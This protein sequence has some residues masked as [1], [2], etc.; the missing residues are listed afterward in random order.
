MI[1]SAIFLLILFITVFSLGSCKRI[2][3]PTPTDFLDAKTF[4]AKKANLDAALSGVYAVLGNSA[5]YGEIYQ[6]NITAGTEEGLV[7]LSSYSTPRAGYF[8]GTSASSEMASLWTILYTGINRA[9]TVLENID[10]PTDITEEERAAIKGEA[11]FLRAY[12]YFLLTQWYGNVPLR[13]HSS[14]SADETNIAFT[15]SKDIY[16]FVIEEMT[17]ADS[18]LAGQTADMFTSNERVTQT[19]V[20][21]ILA[22]VCLYAAGNPVNDASRYQDAASW[23]RKVINSGL[24]Q[25]N[26]DYRQLF[27]LQ[28][29]DQYDNVNRESIWEVGFY[30]NTSSS[31]QNSGKYVRVG[32][33]SSNDLVGRCDGYVLVPP[34]GLKA[35]YAKNLVAV[36]G[37]TGS[38]TNDTTPDSR[39]DW[40][41][42]KFKYSG[43]STTV[44]PNKTALS[45]TNYW[46]RYPGKWRREE[47]LAPHDPTRS[48]A[49][50]PII[51]Y[52]DVLL[53]LAEA[54]NELNGPT[55]EA[56]DLVNQIRKRAY[57]EETSGKMLDSIRIING[58][59]G[60]TSAPTVTI[61]GG[62]AT[63]GATAR[64]IVSGGTV[65]GIYLSGLGSGYTSLPTI[66]ISGTGSGAVAEAVS[67]TDYR[68][69][70]E[71][72][73]SQEAFRKTI[74]DERLRELLGEF[75]RRQDLKRWGILEATVQQMGND[76]ENGNASL[77]IIAFP[78]TQTS[79]AKVHF[80]LPASNVSSK[81]VFLPIPQ[82]E[83]LYNNL[84]EQNPGY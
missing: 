63:T 38:V 1:R 54:E 71:Q 45:P 16:N 20:E 66:T 28:L 30:V 23:A 39:R 19:A 41:I 75:L 57:Q 15:A 6:Y 47:E 62:G 42:A 44:V 34:E 84:A 14:Q 13:T 37:T 69:A 17:L 82:K 77:G 24:H 31:E 29:T 11:V 10:V 60:Y 22:R 56:V 5:L 67:L 12:Y 2:L 46:G 7:F 27:K 61:A 72:Y 81:D 21:A 78:S 55:S 59:S 64:A 80:T 76:A 33:A 35:Y 32:I 26:P 68:L 74:Q 65:T 25:L 79:P 8:N 53:M 70:T 40:N 83:M 18:L 52:A 4:Y 58:G 36:V 48:P 73:A 49:N 43:G 9:N 51:R 50:I 3:E